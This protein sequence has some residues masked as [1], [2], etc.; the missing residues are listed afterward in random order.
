MLQLNRIHK[1]HLK[2]VKDHILKHSRAEVNINDPEKVLS[3]N[4]V[5]PHRK[6]YSVPSKMKLLSLHTSSRVCYSNFKTSSFT[7]T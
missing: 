7:I 6:D 1:L 2:E 5:I 3:A 4:V